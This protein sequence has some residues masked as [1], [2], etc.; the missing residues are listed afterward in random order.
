MGASEL[1]FRNDLDSARYGTVSP[2]ETRKLLDPLPVGLEAPVGFG[3]PVAL[4][5][6]AAAVPSVEVVRVQDPPSLVEALPASGTRR[7][8]PDR[9]D[10]AAGPSRR[11]RER[12]PRPLRAT[13]APPGSA[14]TAPSEC[15]RCCPS[16]SPT[17]PAALCRNCPAL[18]ELS[19]R[20]PRGPGRNTDPCRLLRLRLNAYN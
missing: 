16:G 4:P 1:V 11:P 5:G 20:L 15:R 14:A 18:P 12:T 7:E 8:P 19:C 2:D 3:P 13:S 17:W 9:T 10:D 6:G